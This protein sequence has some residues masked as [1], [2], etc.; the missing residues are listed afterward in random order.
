MS[1]SSKHSSTG[2]V[3]CIKREKW[4]KIQWCKQKK[5]FG[6]PKETFSY[7]S[8]LSDVLRPLLVLKLQHFSV[9]AHQN[10]ISELDFTVSGILDSDRSVGAFCGPIFL[11]NCITDTNLFP[12]SLWHVSCLI[13]LIW[14]IKTQTNSSCPFIYLSRGHDNVQS[15]NPIVTVSDI[16]SFIIFWCSVFLTVQYVCLSHFCTTAWSAMRRHSTSV[17]LTVYEICF[18][19]K[20][21]KMVKQQYIGDVLSLMHFQILF[22]WGCTLHHF[23]HLYICEYNRLVTSKAPKRW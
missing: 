10:S 23:S 19:V 7:R 11:C 9:T 20:I 2:H 18:I 13:L 21:S 3:H 1:E 22:I 16:I 6:F 8:F 17:Q 14:L 15:E 5:H 12:T 4:G